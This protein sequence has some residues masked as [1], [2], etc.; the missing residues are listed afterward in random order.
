MATDVERQ[1][2]PE[3]PDN[4]IVDEM[5]RLNAEGDDAEIVA[6][7][8]VLNA[9]EDEAEGG[10]TPVVETPA[11]AGGATAAPVTAKV[12]PAPPASTP[13]PDQPASVKD[14][15]A[16]LEEHKRAS[17][18]KEERG[19]LDEVIS[20]YAA[21]LEQQY[22]LAPE[23]ASAIARTQGDIVYSNYQ[24]SRMQ[25]AST[26]AALAI[27]KEEGVDP[28]TLLGLPSPAA[29]RERAKQLKTQTASEREIAGLRARVAELEK[30]KVPPQRMENGRSAVR[31]A[32][33]TYSSLLDQYNRG[34]R[35]SETLAA[36]KRAAGL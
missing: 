36:A 28:E 35:T 12:E 32:P 11:P 10:E 18:E 2:V 14:Y 30:G 7:I 1:A 9:R 4:P 15:I 19:V 8:A 27:A 23:Q 3:P 24:S 29:M 21:R 20:Q 26:R 17:D 33:T 5:A 13:T 34:V 25:I 22:G 6:E 16:R 31:T